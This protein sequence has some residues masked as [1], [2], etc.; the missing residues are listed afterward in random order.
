MPESIPV[1]PPPKNSAPHIAIFDT[2]SGAFINRSY[3][4]DTLHPE[5]AIRQFVAFLHAAAAR[6]DGNYAV[7]G[8]MDLSQQD[9]LHT[10]EM[11]DNL[12]AR[13][14]FQM[15]R[16]AREVRRNRRC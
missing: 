14:G 1:P 2:E 16:L 3:D 7:V 4:Y 9:I 10:I 6:Y 11:S 12:D 15:Y 5:D 13:K 8:E